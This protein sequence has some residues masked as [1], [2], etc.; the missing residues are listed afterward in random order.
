MN[1]GGEGGEF[2]DA[3]IEN[4]NFLQGGRGVTIGGCMMTQPMKQNNDKFR[5]N[6]LPGQGRCV[7]DPY[8]KG[9]LGEGVLRSQCNQLKVTKFV[10]YFSLFTLVSYLAF[11]AHHSCFSWWFL[12]C[13]RFTVVSLKS[14]KI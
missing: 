6:L 14:G 13:L 11:R 12:K 2:H 3:T 7:C 10:Y 5:E 4:K 8:Q 1:I 9:R